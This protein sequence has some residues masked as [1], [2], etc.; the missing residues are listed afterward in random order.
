[1]FTVGSVEEG[2]LRQC[3]RFMSVRMA[4]SEA[5]V[6]SGK[7]VLDR[8]LTQVAAFVAV[9]KVGLKMCSS[10]GKEKRSR[11]SQ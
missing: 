4:A 5:I 2:G 3:W 8:R 1:M 6:P 7:S 10:L 9:G 11:E